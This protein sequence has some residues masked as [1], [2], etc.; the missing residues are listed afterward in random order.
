M[1][2]GQFGSPG[3]ARVPTLDEYAAFKEKRGQFMQAQQKKGAEL[4]SKA[5]QSQ[6]RSADLDLAGRLYKILDSRLAKPARKFLNKELAKHVG[7]DPKSEQFRELDN[8]ITSLDPDTL[9]TLRTGFSQQLEGAQPGQ[10][11][12]TI[13]G[14]MTGQVPM[15]EFIDQVGGIEGVAPQQPGGE[16]ISGGAGQDELAGGAAGDTLAEEP[17]AKRQD[18]LTQDQPGATPA[19]TG[20]R[21]YQQGP[22]AI[23]SFEG[24]RTVPSAAQQASPTLVG[25]LGLDSRERYRNNDLIQ[26]GY[27]VPFDPKEQDKVAESINTRA[28]GISGTISEA[29]KMTKLFE[30]RPEVLGP[31]GGAVRTLQ[32]TIRQVEGVIN[33]IN[34]GTK[35]ESDP[36]DPRISYLAKRIGD[37]LAKGHGLD[38]T[39][40]TSAQIQSSVLSLAYRMAI[41]QDIPG[42]RLTNAIITQ[43]LTM[44]GQSASPEQFKKVL[45]GTIAGVTREFD[46]AMK[47]QVGISGMNIITKQLADQDIKLMAESADILP[48][49]LARSLLEEAQRRKS[50]DKGATV[51]PASP[52][53]AEEEQTLGALETEKKAREIQRSDQT[54]SLELQ[55]EQRATRGEERSLD[56]EDRL[57]TA[58]I[59]SQRLQQQQF[60]ATEANRQRDEAFQRETFEYR[61]AQDRKD[62]DAKNAAAIARAFQS[63]GQAIASRGGGSVSGGG[64]AS[65]GG[66]QDVS[67]FRLTPAPQRMPPRPG[68]R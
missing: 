35:N 39:A 57:A 6:M 9:Q 63:F 52:T 64:G 68:G 10:I 2:I 14:I 40:E 12:D 65:V 60:Q 25:A 42:N 62:E 24:Q 53:L 37:K 30:G 28:V 54:Q 43:N 21:P 41:A 48:D 27:R 56:R 23:Q 47:R 1:A 3:Q 61:K 17:P 44:I 13:R 55:R 38:A 51:T 11:T 29:A 31:V 22:G 15:N 58:Q 20:P 19:A 26:A 8:M 7:V 16:A 46:E 50:G 34:P 45:T 66:G 32:S 18:Q 59:E 67:A 33:L 36:T 4:Q 49:D 5:Q